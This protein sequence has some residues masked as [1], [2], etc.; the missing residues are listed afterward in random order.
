MQ[1]E[2][3]TT[4][5]NY[6]LAYNWITDSGIHFID[7]SQKVDAFYESY[8]RHKKKYS[9]LYCEITGYA[10]SFLLNSFKR[11]NDKSILDLAKRAGDF[12][13]LYQAQQGD[14]KGAIPWTV[15]ETG[16]SH[17][18]YY[19]FDTAM[20]M[21]G[22]ADL[23]K[24]TKNEKYLNAATMAAD[25]LINSAQNRDGSFKAVY[26]ANQDSFDSKL[27]E[28]DWSGDRGSLHIKHIMGL[29]KIHEITGRKELLDST[30]KTLRWSREIQNDR[31]AFS[32][33]AHTDYIFTHA[34]CYAAEGIIYAYHFFKNEKILETFL[35][36]L[37]WLL[38]AQ[39]PDGSFFDYYGLPGLFIRLKES[40]NILRSIYHSIYSVDSKRIIRLKR[41]DTTAQAARIL[42]LGYSISYQS[43]YKEAAEKAVGFIDKMQSINKSQDVNGSI[44]FGC[45]DLW[46]IRRKS[47]LYPSWSSLFAGNAFEYLE[48]IQNNKR[49]RYT[50]LLDHL[51]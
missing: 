7:A 2:E 3:I 30:H 25:W 43:K 15:T 50:Y 44:C 51:F 47:I 17:H 21:S 49:I 9:F 14:H 20:S 16:E 5:K 31:G 40:K 35:N 36:S 34:H 4:K 32:A 42:L 28:K 39:N 33:G 22:L 10:I 23:Y 26:D 1:K 18:L 8:N 38:E 6:T 46:G 29:L 48:L 13:V 12:L 41:S 27:L 11:K 24:I 37:D 19:S 45:L